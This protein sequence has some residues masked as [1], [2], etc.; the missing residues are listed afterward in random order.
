LSHQFSE[1]EEDL[2]AKTCLSPLDETDTQNADDNN[3]DEDMTMCSLGA[4]FAKL[5]I[6][7]SDASDA[8]SP[9][10][11]LDAEKPRLP[12]S[13]QPDEPGQSFHVPVPFVFLHDTGANQTYKDEDTVKRHGLD[14]LIRKKPADKCVDVETAGPKHT[15]TTIT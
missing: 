10:N 7:K 13:P 15:K 5:T 14:H 3:D 2:Y 6:G 9:C 12:S 1:P 11:T 4:M 8:D